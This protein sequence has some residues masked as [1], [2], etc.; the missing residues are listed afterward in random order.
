MEEGGNASVVNNKVKNVA[1]TVLQNEIALPS[2]LWE[3]FP[4]SGGWE[5]IS[6]VL[7]G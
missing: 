2:Q 7:V 1:A 4:K 3:I 5:L 6:W